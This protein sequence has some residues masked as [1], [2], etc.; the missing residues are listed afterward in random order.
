MNKL[1]TLTQKHA[2]ILPLTILLVAALIIFAL[3]A[4]K[5]KPPKKETQEKAWLISTETVSITQA[6]PQIELLARVE[7]PYKATLSA[8]LSADILRVPV[9]DGQSV[10]QGE[11]LLQLDARESTLSLS[12]RQA[13]IDELDA[14]IDAEKLRYLSDRRALK[15]ETRLLDIAKQSLDR[16]ASLKASNLVAQERYDNAESSLAKQAL[17]VNARELNVA[18]HPNRLRQLEARRARALTL[19]K[20][21]RIDLERAQIKAP[22]D[23]IITRVTAAPGERVQ[24]GQAL[25]T[26]YDRNNIELR[27]QV[28]DK[29]LSLINNA[30]S[31]GV[32]IQAQALSQQPEVALQL[33]RLSGQASLNN[34]GIDALFKPLSEE[35]N[36]VLNKA[37]RL[38]IDMP[39]LTGVVTLPV[40]AIYGTQRI[41]RV[42]DG[43][44]QSLQVKVLGKQFSEASQD[45]V[46][47]RS[48]LLKE[49]DR[50][51]TTQ[52]PNAISGLKVIERS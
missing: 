37:L 38:R 26:L 39:A 15:E 16:Q 52:L 42:E 48:K 24:L 25:V 11:V 5:P 12:Q 50:I 34:G 9:R 20:D 41:Y 47:I 18:D 14:L 32:H 3:I 43:R 40:S 1:Q 36:L 51:I 7:S 31:Q 28:P 29:Y 33:L 19:L 23:G 35:H 13:D 8:A 46:I 44:L 17:S 30:L 45:R 49:G 27:A 22:F 21:A 4:S 10:K 2:W 6:H